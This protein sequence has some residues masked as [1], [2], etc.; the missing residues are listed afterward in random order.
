MSVPVQM[1]WEEA[2]GAMRLGFR[3]RRPS[4]PRGWLAMDDLGNIFWCGADTHQWNNS[5]FTAKDWQEY[6]PSSS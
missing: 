2:L 1:S 3:I 5:D 4:Q 6:R